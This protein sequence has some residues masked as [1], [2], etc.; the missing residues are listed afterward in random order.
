MCHK[1]STHRA[2]LA[3]S[4]IHITHLLGWKNKRIYR[5]SNNRFDIKGGG[6]LEESGKSPNNHN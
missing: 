6:V 4:A 5:I 1:P 3:I 2:Y